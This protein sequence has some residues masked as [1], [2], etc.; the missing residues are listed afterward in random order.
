MSDMS[1][2]E[3]IRSLSIGDEDGNGDGDGDGDRGS[4]DRMK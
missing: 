2:W 4:D 3:A 1:F